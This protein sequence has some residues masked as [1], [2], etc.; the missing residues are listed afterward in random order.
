MK[1]VKV[2]NYL[3]IDL[4]FSENGDVNVSMIKYV[5]KIIDAFPEEIKST[6]NSPAAGHLFQVREESKTMVLPEE[7]AVEFHHT[8]AQL[9]LM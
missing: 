3:G 8:V 9:L 6:S 2:H 4:Y 1:R 7:Q 5:K